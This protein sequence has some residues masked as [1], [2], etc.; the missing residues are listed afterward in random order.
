MTDGYIEL[1]DEVFK[2]YL[3]A[4]TLSFRNGLYYE[5]NKDNIILPYSMK[6]Y[7]RFL[8]GKDSQA[9]HEKVKCLGRQERP[10]EDPNIDFKSIKYM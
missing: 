6:D 3:D 8:S 5:E 2:T 7:T 10:L 9:R 4:F 1:E